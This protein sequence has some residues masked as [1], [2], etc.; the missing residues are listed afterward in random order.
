MSQANVEIARRSFETWN[1]TQDFDRAAA[2]WHPEIEF[3]LASQLGREA[4]DFRVFHGLDEVREA[5]LDLVAPF[6]SFEIRID[7][8]I[9]L[10]EKVLMVMEGLGRLGGAVVP[11]GPFAYVATVRERKVVRL[12]H[13]TPP[14]EALKAL[15]L[16][17]KQPRRR[18]RRP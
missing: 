4:P 6:E 9:D 7:E 1:E 8:Y 10:G 2:D 5:F 17:T 14:K 12:E 16:A 18:Q 13:F 3:E 15:G 11:T